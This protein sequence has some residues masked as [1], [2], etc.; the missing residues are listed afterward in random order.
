MN[1]QLKI[2]NN[3]SGQ[4][5]ILVLLV[6]V[7]ALTIGLSLI[8][9]STQNIRLSTN[10]ELS[11]R[12]YSAAEA[13][14]EE[15]LRA[16]TTTGTSTPATIGNGNNLATYTTISTTQ[17]NSAQVFSYP[18]PVEV[19]ESIQAWLFNYDYFK[20]NSGAL[21]PNGENPSSY[22]NECA[23]CTN[24]TVYWG[25]GTSATVPLNTAT[26]P[27]IELS[28]IYINSATSLYDIEKFAIDP[29][30]TR[31]NN[32]DSIDSGAAPYTLS[33]TTQGTK[34]FYYKKTI[35]L[36]P[37]SSKKYLLMRAKLLY[38]TDSKHEIAIDP[39]GSILPSQGQV[40]ESQ[41]SAGDII[42][43]IRVYQS[44]PSLPGL[45]D[46]VVFNGSSQPLSK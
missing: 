26:T 12:A 24:L 21:P 22:F 4:M 25:S 8:A 9:R 38:N 45:F 35:A 23:G 32:F 19:N 18:N 6:L 29:S 33:N 17:G 36:S 1:Q 3:Q 20:N 34:K 44:Y 13:G 30:S 41:G 39:N 40:I 43:K 31:G 42:R 27:A 7:I 10:T 2:V 28:L 46:F 16:G 11:N 37:F 15:S 5:V 14:I